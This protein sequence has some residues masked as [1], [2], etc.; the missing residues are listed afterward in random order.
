MARQ[1]LSGADTAWW[2]MEDPASPMTITALL[3]LEGAVDLARLREAFDQRL[4][5][6]ARFRRRVVQA[7]QPGGPLFWED[8]PHFDLDAHLQRIALQKPG[9]QEALQ[10]V[11]SHLIGR[12]LDSSRPLWDFHLIEGYDGG[13]A[14]VARVH[15]CLADG[16]ALV[17]VLHALADP[18]SGPDSGLVSRSPRAPI[19]RQGTNGVSERLFQNSVTALRTPLQLLGIA[20]MGA[21]AAA[22]LRRLMLRVPD[23][24]TAF[25][26]KLGRAKRAAWSEAIALTDAKAIGRATGATVN[27]IMLA[28]LSG[29]L[30]RYLQRHGEPVDGLTIR[31][32]LSVNLRSSEAQPALGNQAGAVLVDLPVGSADPFVRL[33]QVQE[34]MDA[35]KRSPEAAIIAGL[36]QAMGTS[37][38]AIQDAL[39]KTYCTRD[40]AV[41]ANV[42]GP[43]QPLYFVG[44]PLRSFLF[45][46]P[47]FGQVGLSLNISSYAGQI[48]LGVATDRGLVPDPET[49]VAAF[50]AEFAAL[51]GLASAR[52]PD[53]TIRNMHLLLDGAL[54]TVDQMLQALGGR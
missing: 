6:F 12:Q 50:Q 35:L 37:R 39:V 38:Q 46:V 33:Q 10:E 51:R 26:G 22:A 48:W 27:D 23:T 21:G 52:E 28:A 25:R 43:A 8:D 34:Q 18:P 30:R 36:L 3:V 2:R 20:R 31:A 16:P 32:G 9:N 49:I 1:A 17:R 53:E 7:R 14:L 19:E 47:A 29:A 24:D 11:V 44:S 45:W 5:P 4:L 42:P 54:D 41:I 15:H 40:T 13:C